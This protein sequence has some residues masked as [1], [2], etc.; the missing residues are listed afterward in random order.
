MA[1]LDAAQ[2]M[3]VQPVVVMEVKQPLVPTRAEAVEEATPSIA[4][5]GSR[6]LPPRGMRHEVD[7]VPGHRRLRH[8]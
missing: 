4:T 2:H 5:L 3:P 1:S 7:G 6:P 8:L